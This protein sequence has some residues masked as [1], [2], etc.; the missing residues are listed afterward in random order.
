MVGL[1]LEL[2]SLDSHLRSSFSFFNLAFAIEA[3]S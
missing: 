1:L 2:S 3:A